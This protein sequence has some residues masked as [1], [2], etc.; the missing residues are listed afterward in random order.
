MGVMQW[1]SIED[2]LSAYLQYKTI[3]GALKWHCQASI[4]N[5]NHIKIAEFKDVELSSWINCDNIKN[6]TEITSTKRIN[7]RNMVTL[8]IPSTH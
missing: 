7:F 6:Q 3:E 4:Y 8:V 2:S 5:Q 1:M